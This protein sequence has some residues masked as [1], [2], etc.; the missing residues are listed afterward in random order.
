MITR[1]AKS[2]VNANRN[3]E[4][5]LL[6]TE[7]K[8]ML[9]Y[10]LNES[11]WPA[12]ERHKSLL[13]SNPYDSEAGS[14]V[15]HAGDIENADGNL[16]LQSVFADRLAVSRPEPVRTSITTPKERFSFTGRVGTRVPGSVE[17]QRIRE[18]MAELSNYDKDQMDC[19]SEISI[20]RWCNFRDTHDNKKVDF[21][22]TSRMHKRAN[23]SRN[24]SVVAYRDSRNQRAYGEVQFLFRVHLPSELGRDVSWPGDSDSDSADEAPGTALHHLAYI[25]KIEVELEDRLVR[26]VNNTGALAVIAVRTIE[27]LIGRLKVG[28][29]EYLTARFSSMLGRMK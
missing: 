7:Q 17:R 18:F 9:G 27:S 16:S 20:W 12:H 19:P 8:H 29:D 25:R 22:V 15:S 5:T 24:A 23:N 6:L 11:D 21:K 2:R 14:D 28:K 26:R 3:I 10:V 1:T 4:N 13:E